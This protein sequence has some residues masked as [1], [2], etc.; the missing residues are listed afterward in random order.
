MQWAGADTDTNATVAAA[1]FGF[2]ERLD[3]VP[4]GWLGG[5]YETRGGYRGSGSTSSTL[6]SP[7]APS[8][9]WSDWGSL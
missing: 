7:G 5:P 9:E 4:A 8:A 1:L 2:R 3:G 6:R